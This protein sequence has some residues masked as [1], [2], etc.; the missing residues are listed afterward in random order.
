ML[1]ALLAG[2]VTPSVVSAADTT[3][4]VPAAERSQHFDAVHRQLE[5]GG[6]LYGYGDIDGD[7]LRIADALRGVLEGVAAADPQ[8]AAFVRQD[9][10]G[11]FDILGFD[12][13]KAFGFSSV[14]ETGGLYRNRVY[15]HTPKGRRGLLAGLGGGPAPYAML[16][17]APA[18]TD[19]YA[20]TEVDFAEIYKT[21]KAVVTKVGGETSANLVEAKIA[22]AGEQ[23]QVPFL[24]LIN[25]WKGHMA[26]VVRLDPEKNL[27]LPVFTMPEPSVLIAIEGVAPALEALLKSN[28][29]IQSRADKGRTIFQGAPD[30]PA[31][32]VPV[33]LAIDG[34]TLYLASSVEFLDE[35]MEHAAGLEQTPE[36]KEALGHVSA[37]GNGL[38]FV[39]P[40]FFSRLRDVEKLNPNLPAEQLRAI[41]LVL[42]NLPQTTQSLIASRSN[43]PDGIL[44]LSHWDRSLKQD[45]AA[46]TVYNPVTVGL[47]SAMAIPAFQKVRSESQEK[48][49]LNNLRQLAAAADQ[50][51]LEHNVRTTTYDK[52][53]GPDLYVRALQPVAGEDYSSLEFE[54]GKPLV[55]HL[56]DGRT[57]QYPAESDMPP[58][59]ETPESET[60]KSTVTEPVVQNLVLTAKGN[61]RIKVVLES[62]ESELFSGTLKDGE[63]RTIE[64]TGR[65]IVTVE[66]GKLVHAEVDG[67]EVELPPKGNGKFTID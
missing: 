67:N 34:S 28:P 62:D 25:E 21:L 57:I 1:A 23:A 24:K 63:T 14:A 26:M 8:A 29:M 9:F 31:A 66:K 2:A 4:L 46:L 48:A 60:E 49:V 22:E 52:L 44:V 36:F 61:T 42:N 59:P 37:T 41:H 32:A 51:Y 13:V 3:P 33:V 35:C 7:L 45:I 27:T 38:V 15:F 58:V 30:S 12:D 54:E 53:V 40:R 55:V 18:T 11:I 56:A 16:K 10:R 64:K 50:Y 47:L 20:E 6:T 39:S 17:L 65:V 5:L 19:L 43:L